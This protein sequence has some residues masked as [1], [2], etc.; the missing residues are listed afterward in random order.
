MELVCF[1]LEGVLVLEIWISFVEK[2]GIEELKVIMWD[3]LDY[4]VL[5]K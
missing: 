4:D 1:D 2:I 3:I 5:M